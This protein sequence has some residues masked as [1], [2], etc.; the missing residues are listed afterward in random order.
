MDKIRNFF[1]V[2]YQQR[3]WLLCG[4]A[5]I[6]AAV[7]WKL[8]SGALQA[9]FAANQSKITGKFGDMQKISQTTP[10]GNDDVNAG[11]LAQAKIV[12]G[13]VLKLWQQLYDWQRDSVLKWPETLGEAFLK[14][15][16][17][18]QF[19]DPGINPDLRNIY[20][21]Y[22]KKRFPKLVAIVD[23]RK[24]AEADLTSGG[25]GRGEFGGGRF[26]SGGRGEMPGMMGTALEEEEDF[27]VEWP[28]QG[29]L[30]MKL[31]FP[32]QPSPL[33]IWVTQEDLWVYETLLH[34]IA[35]TNRAKGATRP[36]NAAVRVIF[37]LQVGREAAIA[38]MTKGQIL[39]P[40]SADGGFAGG[41][42]GMGMEGDPMMMSRG[43]GMGMGM[44]ADGTEVSLDTMLLSMRYIDEEGKA[45]DGTVDS[46]SA[47]QFRKLPVRMQLMMDQ[48]WLPVLL[49][50]CA[51]ATLPIEV[52]RVSLNASKSGVGFEGA[53]AGAAASMGM[54]MGGSRGEFAGYGGGMT[55]GRGEFGSGGGGAGF[56]MPTG[57]GTSELAEVEVQGFVYIYNP[58]NLTELTLPGEEAEPAPESVAA[59]DG[60]AS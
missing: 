34:V 3:F 1:R 49:V 36:D 4:I 14:N 8:A 47:G 60:S 57:P 20:W 2:V 32:R 52:R 15:I 38:S 51:N 41:E 59:T 45:V 56:Q 22:I 25:G 27:I 21:N 12:K 19:G 46:A 6:V 31:D 5:P 37:S 44:A 26:E 40:P 9:E 16:E 43:E 24:M 48:R 58:P 50:E 23:A 33:Q 30:R 29:E 35:N 11:E 10:H 42:A 55:G 17:N 39:M 18:K 13:N 53:M 54:G 7:C 28:S